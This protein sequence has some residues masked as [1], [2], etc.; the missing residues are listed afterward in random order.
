V[1][2]GLREIDHTVAADVAAVTGLHLTLLGHGPMARLGE[3]FLRNFCYTTLLADGLMRVALFEVDG[4]PA[5]FVAYTSRS[6]TFHRV[7]VRRHAAYVAWLT[8]RFVLGDP[9]RLGRVA[10]AV[11]LM[12]SRRAEHDLAQDPLGEVVAIGVLPEYR[13]PEFVRGTGVAVSEA[14]VTHAMAR[15][16]AEGVTRMR[17]VVEAHNTA[18]LLFYHRLGARFEPYEHAGEPMVHVWFDLDAEP[19]HDAEAAPAAAAR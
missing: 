12:G 4:R 14:L 8:A 3:P 17:M 9:R 13:S 6:I 1:R 2:A 15:L 10:K 19:A 11:W 16:R 7:A 18:T 5:G